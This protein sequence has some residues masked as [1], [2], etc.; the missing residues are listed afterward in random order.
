MNEGRCDERLKTRVEESTCLTYTRYTGFARQNKLEIQN[1]TA[2]PIFFVLVQEDVSTGWNVKL[3]GWDLHGSHQGMC[4][5][6]VLALLIIGERKPNLK[7]QSCLQT[8]D[9]YASHSWTEIQCRVG[10]K[11]EGGSKKHKEVGNALTVRV[12]I[13]V[14]NGILWY[15]TSV[16]SSTTFVLDCCCLF[17]AE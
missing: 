17:S 11:P 12:W 13:C 6:Q 16:S 7:S 9:M 2:S 8:S 15:L 10:K 4:V 14:G 1:S 5:D 3:A